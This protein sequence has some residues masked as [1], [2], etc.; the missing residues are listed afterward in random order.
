MIS[1]HQGTRQETHRLVLWVSLSFHPRDLWSSSAG[2]L[3]TEE[4]SLKTRNMNSQEC[5]MDPLVFRI[6]LNLP[7][8]LWKCAALLVIAPLW[9]DPRC[10]ILLA[11]VHHS[12]FVSGM[13]GSAPLV[14][15]IFLPRSPLKVSNLFRET[16]HPSMNTLAWIGIFSQPVGSTG[17]WGKKCE[18]CLFKG[19]G[20]QG[21]EEKLWGKKKWTEKKENIS[22]KVKW[23]QNRAK[24]YLRNTFSLSVP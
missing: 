17:R 3:H 9:C 18:S 11:S 7:Q 6:T 4:H 19:P 20:N 16:I 12:I 1:S 10:E 14:E 23:I 8:P 5:L 24:S 22:G 21:S 2:S 15:G 13:R